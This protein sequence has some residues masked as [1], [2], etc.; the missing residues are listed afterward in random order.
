MWWYWDVV[1]I[2]HV[3]RKAQAL[4]ASF[5]RLPRGTRDTINYCNSVRPPARSIK[6]KKAK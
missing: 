3:E 4:M 1:P 2:A 5:D 6:E